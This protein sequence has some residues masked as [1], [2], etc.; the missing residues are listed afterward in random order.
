MFQTEIIYAI[1]SISFEWL[2]KFITLI[3]STGTHQFILIVLIII[4]FGI[5]F[6]KGVFIAQTVIW[7]HLLTGIF[8]KHKTT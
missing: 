2:T 3:D 4:I 6:E 5:N 1:Q 8:K 7:T